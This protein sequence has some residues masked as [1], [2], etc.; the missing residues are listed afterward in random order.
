[1][2]VES[3]RWRGAGSQPVEVPV[4]QCVGLRVTWLKR[5]CTTPAVCVILGSEWQS[6]ARV[7]VS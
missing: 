5:T 1:M 3:I 2:F 6:D 4:G 7:A